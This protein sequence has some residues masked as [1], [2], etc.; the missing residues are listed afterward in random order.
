MGDNPIY[1][2]AETEAALAVC[3]SE[4]VHIPACIQPFGILIHLGWPLTCVRQ[5]SAN[6]DTFLG[7][8]VQEALSTSPQTL[9]GKKVHSSLR[10]ALSDH[11]Q[12]PSGLIV[13]RKIEGKLKRF[14]VMAFRTGDSVVV[15]LEPVWQG[16]AHHW[17]SSILKSWSI[18]GRKP[19]C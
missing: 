17:L 5:V 13:G 3:G 8:S 9:L 18:P 19:P 14:N 16:N 1:S 11:D 12:M 15:E 4:P 6:I 10:E 7:I 2:K